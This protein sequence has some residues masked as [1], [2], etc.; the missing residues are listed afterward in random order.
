MAIAFV[1][2]ADGGFS[3]F[4]GASSYS[5]SYTCGSGT[6]RLL[7]VNVVGDASSDFITG[8]TYGGN[9]M[10]LLSKQGGR[11]QYFF[12][13]FNPPSGSNTV[14]IT[15]SSSCDFIFSGAADYS[16]VLQNHVD[17]Q[18]S[19]TGQ[20]SSATTTVTTINDN[21]WTILFELAFTSSGPIAGTGDVLRVSDGS[22]AHIWG[23]FD[24]GG[25]ITPPQAYSMTTSVPGG[26]STISHLV[27]AFSPFN[28]FDGGYSQTIYKPQIRKYY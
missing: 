5:Y 28:P 6:N 9:S 25:V 15:A 24:S 14:S 23:I 26:S 2:S 3:G 20:S 8:V 21:D 19:V 18:G 4:G 27:G 11:W 22:F 17:A 12:Y 16:G 10:T 13:L 1:G 7:V